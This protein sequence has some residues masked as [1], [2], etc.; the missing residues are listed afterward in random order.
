M[1]PC[2]LETTWISVPECENVIFVSCFLFIIIYIVLNDS[3]FRKFVG[4]CG[5]NNLKR[6]RLRMKSSVYIA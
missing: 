3:K 1:V 4:P 5:L 6:D 2:I